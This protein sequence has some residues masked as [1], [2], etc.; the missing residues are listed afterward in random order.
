MGRV[1]TEVNFSEEIREER[2][3]V[4]SPAAT[5]SYRSS[6]PHERDYIAYKRL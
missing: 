1:C 6:V 3:Q 2:Q 4:G 5:T